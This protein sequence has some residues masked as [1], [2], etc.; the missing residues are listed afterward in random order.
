MSTLR[1]IL[2]D[3]PRPTAEAHFVANTRSQYLGQGTVLCQVLGGLKLF[4][5]GADVGF[6][7]HMLFEGYWEYWLTRHFAA[8]IRPGDTVIDIGANLGY[9]TLLAA[10]LVGDTGQVIAVE[11]N[12]EVFRRL[13]ASIAVNG[14]APRVQPRNWAIAAPGESGSRRFF[15]P[16]GEPKNGRFV[17]AGEDPVW[18]A[19]HGTLGEV[20]LGTLDPEQFQRVDFIKIDVE[21]AELAVLEHL[22]PIL[23]RFRPKVVCEVNFARGYGWDEV[24]HAFGTDALTFLDFD[25]TV[26]P[27][28]RAMAETR[29]CGEDWLVCVDLGRPAQSIRRPV[30]AFATT[31]VSGDA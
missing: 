11:P 8:V 1:R 16:T 23:E 24:V 18:L 17:A 26:K 29:Q 25:S 14:F 22:R 3:N 5:I 30:D 12:P 19:A 4:A 15:V 20:A 6:T 9:Y 7:P 27:L 21:G 13:A 28:T 2:L 31:P 10:D